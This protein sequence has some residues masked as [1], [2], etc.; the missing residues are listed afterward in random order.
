MADMRPLIHIGYVKTGSTWL[1]RCLFHHY[2]QNPLARGQNTRSALVQEILVYDDFNFSGREA[3]KRLDEAWASSGKPD[4][5][6]VWSDETLLGDPCNRRY[7]AYRNGQK[8]YE[9][10]P[11]GKVLICIREQIGMAIS[12][13]RE[14]VRGGGRYTL[15]MIVGTGREKRGYSPILRPEYLHYHGAIAFYQ[16]L[17]G[18]DNVLVLPYELLKTAPEDFVARVCRFANLPPVE[19]KA[20]E[21]YNFGFRGA[22]LALL[23][24]LNF[25]SVQNPLTP[26]TGRA[27]KMAIRIATHAG[28]FIP[29]SIDDRFERK[30]RAQ[31]ERRYDGMFSE[32][33][34]ITS[35]LIG[36]D[37]KSLGYQ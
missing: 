29:R 36:V 17:F 22:N 18:V 9:T 6:P 12:I 33:N 14:I 28:R 27:H 5:V 31:V 2:E 1:Q 23:R 37:L 35:R 11:D 24:R 25:F 32:S 13:Y 10:F 26:G 15:E 7:D 4:S 16:S 21:I 8:L 34:A 20:G 3:R 19:L 30:L